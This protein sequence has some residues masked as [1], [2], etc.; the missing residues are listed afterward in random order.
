LVQWAEE[1]QTAVTALYGLT[2]M[3]FTTNQSYR[4]PRVSE[5]AILRSFY[6]SDEED[7]DDEVEDYADEEKPTPARLLELR[8]AAAARSPR[9]K[10]G[11]KEARIKK[12][13]KVLRKV[14]ETTHEARRKAVQLVEENKKNMIWVR[15]SPAS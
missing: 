15:M 13:E 14:R 2:G 1:L 10:I 12:D 6:E 11:A 8:T 9:I 5:E 3:F 4:P 7:D